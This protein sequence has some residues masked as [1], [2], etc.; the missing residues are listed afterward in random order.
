MP[1]KIVLVTFPTLG[2]GLA[3]FEDWVSKAVMPE[4]R[5][6]LV[7]NQGDD[8][9]SLGQVAEIGSRF[10][11]RVSH[12]ILPDTA[13]KVQAYNATGEAHQDLWDILV[14]ASDDMVP[15]PG[16]DAAVAELCPP[17]GA[18]WLPTEVPKLGRKPMVVGSQLYLRRWISMLPILSRPWHQRFGY[19]Y[20][21]A[22]RAFWCD[23]EFTEVARRERRL[24]FVN[25][26]DLFR[27]Q[28]PAWYGGAK[29]DATYQR[30][31]SRDFIR[32]RKIFEAR[33]SRGFPL[34]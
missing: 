19:I 20:H 18:L 12:V 33:K 32:D 15:A 6:A 24:H 34:Y 5:F 17:T 14:G 21:P 1:D 9:V 26:P 28:H 27:H 3:A 13:S 8:T 16:W 31:P 25:R 4:T 23:N 29:D 7:T 2:R 10:S 30:Y 11:R 22:Y